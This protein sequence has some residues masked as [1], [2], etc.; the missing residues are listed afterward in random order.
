M[1]RLFIDKTFKKNAALSLSAPQSHYL[2]HVMRLKEGDKVICFNGQQGDWES[3]LQKQ[4]KEWAILPQKQT[5]PQQSRENCALCLALIKREPLVYA[6]QKATELGVTEIHLIQAERSNNERVNMERLR[7]IVVESCEQ[8]ERND[9]PQ[10]FAPEPLAKK[11]NTFSGKMDLV[12]LS[13]RGTTCGKKSSLPP[14]FFIGPEGGWSDKEQ[15]LLQKSQAFS[16][17]LGNTILRAE[18]AAVTAL[19]LWQYRDEIKKLAI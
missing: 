8:C 2:T 9:I 5:A 14:A 12:W 11:I 18:T 4:K 17:H 6:L 1:S 3:L 15:Q 10:L 7:T 13:E 16:W 19:A